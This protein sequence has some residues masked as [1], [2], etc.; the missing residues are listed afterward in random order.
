[1]D[2][3]SPSAGRGRGVAAVIF[4]MDGVVTDTALLHMTAWKNLFDEAFAAESL[5]QEPFD[6]RKDY[7][8]HL[9][10][11][12]RE[13]GVRAFLAARGVTVSEG[14]PED[15]AGEFTVHGLAKRKQDFFD[16]ALREKDVE[17]FPDSLR[18]LD[19]LREA[20]IPTALVTSSRNSGPI[21]ENAGL[22]DR[23]RERVDG[24]VVAEE[25][26]AGKP[27][28][29][30]FLEA[31]RRLDAIPAQCIVLEDARSGVQAAHDGG[32]GLVVG[33]DRGDDAAELWEA[34]A[35]RVLRDV[36][37]LDLHTGWQVDKGEQPSPWVLSYDS[38]VPESEAT[39]ESLCALA[40]GFWGTRAAAPG[41]RAGDVH[42]PGTYLA[43]VFNR[44]QNHA[45]GT[46]PETEHL[47]NAPDWTFLRLE[48][49]DGDPVQP[50]TGD[51]LDY[52]QELDLRSGV[53]RRRVRQRDGAGRITR[54]STEQFQSMSDP[55]LAALQLTVEPENW[56]GEVRVHSA[57]NGD[58]RNTNVAE[59][60]NLETRHLRPPHRH[61]LDER[62]VMLEATTTQSEVTIAVA[63]RT[64]VS[65][66]GSHRVEVR[67]A[68]FD[69]AVGQ[70]FRS[71]V[72]P[73]EPLTVDKV[74][75][76]ATS[77][78]RALS[79][80][81]LDATKRITRAADYEDLRS[82]HV[83]RWNRLWDIFRVDA[84]VGR[85]EAM[86]LNLHT[87]H[88]LQSVAS[89]DS[90]LD[91]GVPARGLHG[92]GY[93]GHI[94]W[95]EQF[96]YP[97][98]TLRQPSLTRSLLLYRYRRLREARA[99][100]HQAGLR[101][102]LF[103]WQ[104]GSDGREETPERLY[105]P[106][107][108]EWM[109]DNSRRQRHVG[110]A[111]ASSVWSYFQA[112]E[113][114]SFLRDIGAELIIEIA[115]LFASNAEYLA[116]E[117]RY[118]I[119]GVMG[120]DEYHDG[121][122]DSPGEGVRDNAYT[123]VLVAWTLARVPEA[124]DALDPDDARMLREW[125][126][127]TDEELQRW[128][129]IGRRLRIPF[130]SDGVISQFEGYEQL[131]ELDW[132]GYQRK[133]E[134]IS[135]LDLILQAEGD[136][137]NAY[138]LSKQAD[139]LMLFYLFSVDELGQILERLGYELTPDAVSRTIEFYLARSSDGSTLSQLVHAWVLAAKD[140]TR[141][142]SAFRHAL[143]ADLSD[144]QGSSA[145]EG[146]HVGALAGTVD[147]ILRNYG[148]VEIREGYLSLDPELPADL[149]EVA[150]QLHYR[151]QPIDVR[152]TQDHVHLQL[153]PGAGNPVQ[154]R[155]CG[156][157]KALKP[158]DVWEFALT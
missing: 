127:L 18:L 78:D 65:P 3:Q 72:A 14:G 89:V 75:V 39:R 151:G 107:S 124:L 8:R 158:G 16:E 94:F 58:V 119:G 113:D 81:R 43:G 139:T 129:H 87:F 121:Y 26:M 144:D 156:E 101:G 123:N 114:V 148:G 38:F 10:G 146:V 47:I 57:I 61:H 48:T 108:Q 59:D 135:R 153:T 86:A 42:Y 12:T 145:A 137:P 120:P 103:P 126:D 141:S 1:M 41:S 40:N 22:L 83:Q 92:E 63:T 56:G 28:P 85:R 88:V 68:D 102:A 109:P 67:P 125:L 5:D 30:M 134:D 34:G 98:L 152:I 97:I 106:R 131:K 132:E 66:S 100:A 2:T 46:P 54:I 154:V 76:A 37:E 128:D 53:L 21:L 62:T 77:R 33:V 133:Y 7:R 93:R 104:S 32:F 116:D 90:D 35:D 138:R 71:G 60:R 122:P 4:D 80:P 51:I 140:R 20:G 52:H 27:D 136:T 25:G 44:V 69:R 24:T 157:Q 115:R 17:L 96:V 84:A 45:E 50:G 64:S 19:R 142:W 118:S 70:E 150:F 147:M 74:A 29:A 79:T 130:H 95:D 31:A 112:T 9:D 91:A 49:S 82:A 149:P 13:D 15:A 11:L 73:G 155:V 143:E 117:D 36:A 110:L 99:A 23:F 6:L 111:I 105:N 55:H